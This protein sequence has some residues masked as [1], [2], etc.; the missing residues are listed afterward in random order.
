ML[1]TSLTFSQTILLTEGFET[2]APGWTV[3]HTTGNDWAIGSTNPHTGSGYAVYSYHITQA[4]NSYLFFP[5]LTLNAGQQYAIEFWQSVRSSSYPEKFELTVGNNNTIAAQTITVRDYGIQTITTYR[6]RIAYFTPSTSGTYYF[7]FHAY[8]NA[9]EWD[10][11]VDDVSVWT[12]C[13]NHSCSNPYVIGSLPYSQTGLTTCNSCN[14]YDETDG[15]GSPFLNQAEN[16]F[17]YTPSSDGWVDVQL[18]TSTTDYEQGAAVFVM[19]NCPSNPS[20][21]CIGSSTV[22]Y[23]S[24][25]GSPHTT[26]ELFAGTTYYIVVSNA[27]D[28][29]VYNGDGCIDYNISVT[30]VVQPNPNAQDCFGA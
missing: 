20:A 21:N 7:A 24:I 2:T 10:L 16:V 6:H 11:Q 28:P 12:D 13:N 15:C 4:A 22:Q 30:N 25:H 8:S 14:N 23:P 5:S 19:D 18:T 29:D 17:T 1:F 26:V 3:N 9:N 27:E